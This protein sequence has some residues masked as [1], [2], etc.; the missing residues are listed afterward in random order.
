MGHPFTAHIESP[1]SGG[2]WLREGEDYN[3][4]DYEFDSEGGTTMSVD[5][6]AH[7][8]HYVGNPYFEIRFIQ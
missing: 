6:C 1:A 5:M 2:E 8:D 3:S 4:S 7:Y